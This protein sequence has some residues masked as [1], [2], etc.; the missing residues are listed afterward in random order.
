MSGVKLVGP[1][2]GFA[3]A[4]V[5]RL[6]VDAGLSRHYKPQMINALQGRIKTS[7]LRGVDAERGVMSER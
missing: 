2:G 4:V 1:N 6:V 3:A 5:L 7:V